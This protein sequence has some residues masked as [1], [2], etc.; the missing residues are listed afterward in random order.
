MRDARGPARST[1]REGL[2][3]YHNPVRG[4]QLT[5]SLQALLLIYQFFGLELPHESGRLSVYRPRDG[6]C[7]TELACGGTFS[8]T[9]RHIA[10]RRWWAVGC[11]RVVLVHSVQTGLWSASFVRDGGPYGVYRGAIRRCVQ[12]GRYRV[13]S[14]RERRR[15]RPDR[16]WTWRGL[17]DLSWGLWL[18]L[19]SPD[20]LSEVRLYF[21]PW[22][23]PRQRK[24]G[25]DR[26][27]RRN[28]L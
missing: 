23:Q 18:D 11:G 10:Y 12:D 20:F 28:L 16:G 19:G 22:R 9:S 24:A 15:G 25:G 17:T 8:E 14:R 26:S 1:W 4:R 3:P 13:A 21:F 6:S 7:G 27:N 2:H 5:Q